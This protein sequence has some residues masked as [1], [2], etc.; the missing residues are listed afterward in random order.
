MISMRDLERRPDGEMI[1]YNLFRSRNKN[2]FIGDAEPWSDFPSSRAAFEYDPL[3]ATMTIKQDGLYF[4]Y[5]Q[6]CALSWSPIH[7]RSTFQIVFTIAVHC[8]TG[9]TRSVHNKHAV[10]ERRRVV[11]VPTPPGERCIRSALAH[12][13]T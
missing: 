7:L 2:I 4:V 13:G 11:A 5:V 12:Y 10:G 6:A 8:C 9:G 1:A 3:Q